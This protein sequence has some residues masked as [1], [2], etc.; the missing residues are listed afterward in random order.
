MTMRISGL[1]SGMD[2]DEIVSQM[3]T[4]QRIPLD[5]IYQKKTYT[6]W[7]RDDYRTMNTALDEFDKLIADGIGR[8]ATFIQKT[9]SISNPDA[10]SVKNINSTFDFSGTIEKATLA[11]AATMIS[12]TGADE[13]ITSSTKLTEI[14]PSYKGQTIKIKA[15]NKDG[16]FDQVAKTD[17]YGNI[18][19]K[20]GTSIFTGADGKPVLSADGKYFKADSEGKQLVGEGNL[21]DPKN[22]EIAMEDKWFEYTIKESDTLQSVIDEINAK[23]GVAAFFDEKKGKFSITAKNTGDAGTEIAEIQLQAVTV[24][25][26]EITKTVTKADGTTEEVKV[27]VKQ[28]ET[29]VTT[30]NFFKDIMKM[31][32]N[33]DIAA[34]TELEGVPK[35]ASG[36]AGTNAELT[37]N[38][39][40]IERSS[41]TFRINGAEITLKQEFTD[42]VTFS[43]TPDV[44]KIF[45]KVKEFVDSYNALI[46]NISGKISEKKDSDY[47]PLTDEQKKSLEEE[48]IK[49]WE[50]KAKKGT[51]RNDSTLRG[52][53]TNMRTALYTSV[54]GTDFGHLSSIGITT[55]KSYQE[56][57]KLEID[58]EKLRQA[59]AENPNGVFELFMSDDGDA[60]STDGD[61]LARRLRANLSSAVKDIAEKAGR[62]AAS[63]NNT[64]TL[65]R[66]LD[67]Y[68]DKISAFEKR[69]TDLETRYYKQFTNMEKMISQAN[70]QSSYL[71]SYFSS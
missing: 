63:V 31:E 52:L 67:D 3:M 50:E 8:Q 55:T 38:G 40:T 24:E 6:E 54:E 27:Q 60:K 14:D 66:L 21:I 69:L 30:E 71:S 32:K 58:E 61:G 64:F 4:A 35:A 25:T 43:S 19:L 28:S 18:V 15:I 37:Y 22:V 34:A 39:L 49:R 44:D 70:S 2:I 16:S 36:T 29:E 17:S 45:D 57:G 23:S 11:K 20:D 33:S 12:T 41:N 56:G 5:K 7:Q 68:E 42:P 13:T 51:L 1:A 10:F 62:T 59:I 53:L 9:V 48:D 47:P 65:G 26:K 46:K